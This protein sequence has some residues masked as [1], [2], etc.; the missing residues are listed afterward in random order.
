MSKTVS[1]TDLKTRCLEAADMVGSSFVGSAELEAAIN[2]AVAELYDLCVAAYGPAYFA[3]S[4]TV[5]TVAGQDYVPLAGLLFG[6]DFYQLLGIDAAIDGEPVTLHPFAFAARNRAGTDTGQPQLYR[7]HAQK[8]LLSPIPDAVYTLTVHYVPVA[9]TLSAG[10][11]TTTLDGINGWEQYVIASVAAVLLA[12]EESDP[13]VWLAIKA[14]VRRRI[15]SMSHNRDAGAPDG[16]VDVR[17]HGRAY[18]GRW[19]PV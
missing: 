8:I 6:S 11:A 12:K 5:D 18:P 15:E 4:F 17:R 9:P 10:G 13:G 16:V 19:Q 3:S 1:L 14:D 7:L 2:L